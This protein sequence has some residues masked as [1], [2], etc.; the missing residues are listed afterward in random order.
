MPLLTNMNSPDLLANISSIARRVSILR[1]STGHP[2]PDILRWI[3]EKKFVFRIDNRIMSEINKYGGPAEWGI[4]GK[5]NFLFL[6][7]LVRA[8]KP[9]IIV[10]TGVSS[11]S[12][13]Y[14]FLQALEKNGMGVLYSIDYPQPWSDGK[15]SWGKKSG[16]IV[17]DRLRQRWKL[18]FGKSHD[19]LP[20]LLEKV[21]SIDLFFHDSDHTYANMLFEFNIAWS[22]LKKDGLLLSHDVDWNHAFFDFCSRV[23]AKPSIVGTNI[24]LV[25]K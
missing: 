21:R 6:Y 22:F 4:S 5:T 24:G 12:S 11:G 20:T 3:Y 8:Y 19:L 23:K 17:P 16:W 13:S 2:I 7:S 14:V 25:R 10:E 15:K 9:K 18:I 1:N